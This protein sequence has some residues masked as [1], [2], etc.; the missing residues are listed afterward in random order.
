M[1]GAKTADRAETKSKVREN[2]HSDLA[3]EL[4]PPELSERALESFTRHCCAALDTLEDI[5]QNRL[6]RIGNGGGAYNTNFIEAMDVRSM[7]VSA[8]AMARTALMRT[9]SRCGHFREDYPLPDEDWTL[10]IAIRQ[11]EDGQ[12]ILTKNPIVKTRLD[13][14]QVELPAFPVSGK[15]DR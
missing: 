7:I 12:Y 13:P 4:G 15:I 14:E 9:E 5:K 11:D 6:P 2:A 8:E 1:V 3:P 10:N